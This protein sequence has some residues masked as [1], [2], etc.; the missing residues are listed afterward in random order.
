MSFFGHDYI[1]AHETLGLEL[2]NAA[3]C[4][5]DITDWLVNSRDTVVSIFTCF[6]T[7]YDG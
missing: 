1:V 4:S 3:I 5:I 2:Q 7:V 6:A